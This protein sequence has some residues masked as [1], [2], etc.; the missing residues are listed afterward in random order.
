MRAVVTAN[1]PS[2]DFAATEA[3]F[4]T[5]AVEA[6]WWLEAARSAAS[7]EACA[8]SCPSPNA[9]WVYTV[10]LAPATRSSSRNCF[11]GTRFGANVTCMDA[12]PSS[13]TPRV[14]AGSALDRVPAA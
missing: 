1:L 8:A 6:P 10:N 12:P 7:C 2:R 5:T 9:E 14:C 13:M 3:S 11:G 4:V